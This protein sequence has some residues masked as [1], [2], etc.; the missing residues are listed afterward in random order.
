MDYDK[1]KMDPAMIEQV[2]AVQIMMLVEAVLTVVA[3][4]LVLMMCSRS[5][6]R[7]NM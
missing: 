2:I 1:D 4:T 5:R 7:R 6:S 3:V